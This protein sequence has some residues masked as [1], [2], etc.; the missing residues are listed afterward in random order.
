M[1]TSETDNDYTIGE[2]VAYEL[3]V[4]FIEGVTTGVLVTDTLDLG[5]SYT[6]LSATIIPAGIHISNEKFDISYDD[7]NRIITF[8]LGTV[9]NTDNSNDTDNYLTIRYNALVN[10]TPNVNQGNTKTNSAKVASGALESTDTF[11]VDIIEPKLN[12]EK[13]ITS[14][15]IN[16]QAG[17][18]ITYQVTISH[19]AI[20]ADAFDIELTDTMPAGLK[21]DPASII[22]VGTSAT[23][24]VSGDQTGLTLG[25]A[26]DFDLADGDTVTI[27]YDAVLQT[28]ITQGQNFI[29]DAN[30]TW[31]SLDGNV[32]GERDGSGGVNDY[33]DIDTASANAYSHLNLDKSLQASASDNDFTIGELIPYELRVEVIEGT[34]PSVI[35]KDVLGVG[36]EYQSGSASIYFPGGHISSASFDVNYDAGTRTLTFD[37]GDVSNVGNASSLDDYFIVRYNGVVLNTLGV[38]DGDSINNAARVDSGSLFHEDGYSIDIVEPFLQIDKTVSDSQPNLGEEITFTLD[39]S[40]LA[41]SHADAHDI[42]IQDIIPSGLNYVVGSA[43]L[44]SG[45]TIDES[46]NPSISFHI[47]VLGLG[48]TASITYKAT[49]AEVGQGVN[50]G[51]TLT[52][53]VSMVWDTLAGDPGGQQIQRGGDPTA[54][55]STANDLNADDDVSVTIYGADLRVTKDDS[56]AHLEAGD[57]TIY[58]IVVY[59]DGNEEASNVV[60][61]DHFPDTPDAA[62]VAASNGGVY[63]NIN[64]TVTWNIASIAASDS[65]TLTVEMQ[66]ADPLSPDINSVTNTV[67]VSDDGTHGADPTP[68]NNE[69]EDINAV[70]AVPDLSVTK[71]DGRVDV[72]ANENL[73]YTLN[74]QNTGNQGATGVVV[75]DTLPKELIFVSASHGG[76]YNAST[77]EVV[78]DMGTV[79]GATNQ[80]LTLVVRTTGK[81]DAGVEN[82]TNQ[83]TIEDDGNNGPDP[84]P[85]NNSDSDTDNIHGAPDLVVE[86]D[87]GETTLE[88]DQIIQ[89]TI[90][91]SNQGTKESTG[92]VLR[93]ELPQ[94]LIYL[95]SS[96]GGEKVGDEIHWNIGSLKAGES[97][98]RTISFQVP[99]SME[100]GAKIINKAVVEDDRRKW[101]RHQSRQ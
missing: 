55:G 61:V 80:N 50:L 1:Q 9:T 71:D 93:D 19:E 3:K 11:D 77:H 97:V 32:S 88:P 31:T 100:F 14:D 69:A 65:L 86:K 59:N 84:T 34:T 37:L 53:D 92:V 27:T 75:R 2:E 76:V 33:S 13:Q 25:I 63:D 72:N 46:G 43:V 57:S 78:W 82:F 26:G 35:L 98:K 74:V 5:L 95:Y 54:P 99:N 16:L 94:N 23:Y 38:N 85:E 44:P 24:Q 58:E 96:D 73:V 64:H 45:A 47:P 10:N 91:V 60:V 20:S 89:Y 49:V 52:N 90:R 36:T 18:R 48:N 56:T 17:D 39:I 68:D 4:S 62:F 67:E 66:M 81:I 51:D 40:H 15:T 8:D 6:A 28:S 79:L 12:V 7:V 30:L 83:V 42:V 21:I 87:D 22:L 101:K 29:N 70:G 41:S